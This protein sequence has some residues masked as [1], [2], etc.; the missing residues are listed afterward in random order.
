MVKKIALLVPANRILRFLKQIVQVLHQKSLKNLPQIQMP[1]KKEILSVFQ[2][3]RNCVQ[4]RFSSSA[5]FKF[6][7]TLRGRLPHDERQAAA[8]HHL[9]PNH[10]CPGGA[11]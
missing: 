4:R 9:T 10:H 5:K 7:L 11:L 2:Q 1:S 8:H 6:L 3:T